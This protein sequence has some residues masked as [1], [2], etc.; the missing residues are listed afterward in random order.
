VDLDKKVSAMQSKFHSVGEELKKVNRRIKTLKEHIKHSENFKENRKIKTQYEKLYA[1]YQTAKKE[2]GFFAERKAQKALDAVN[3][4]RE[5]Y[6]PQL[7]M[8]DNAVE[9]LRGVLQERFDPKKLPPI[10]KWRDELAAKT[11]ERSALY[12]KYKAIKDE[13]A[14]VEKIKRSV[15]EIL[16]SETP[17]TQPT[18]TQGMEL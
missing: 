16:H 11:A 9:Y 15:A 13:T 4:Y 14:R 1:E 10:T 8:F 2:K 6:R 7:A 3:E 12:P 18:R 5:D 17:R